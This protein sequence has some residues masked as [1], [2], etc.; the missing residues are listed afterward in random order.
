M[1]LSVQVVFDS[2]HPHDLADWWAGTLG[3]EVEVQDED[4]I[5]RMIA[6]G[7]ATEADTV[8]YGGALVWRTGA[9]INPPG[10][11]DRESAAAGLG[12]PRILF[13]HTDDVAESR[14][15]RVH[16][17]LRGLADDRE[18]FYAS[19]LDRGATRLWEGREGPHT[20]VTFADPEG[21]E[22]CA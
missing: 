6:E 18:E 19:L 17:D 10:T 16:L 9:A 22:F 5:H 7:H 8:R 21:N 1:A 3:W 20:W 11:G 2:A 4:F 13:Q 15:N 14:K 12:A